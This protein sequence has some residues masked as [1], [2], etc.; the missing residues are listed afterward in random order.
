LL[1]ARVRDAGG[2]AL[3]DARYFHVGAEHH[4]PAGM[5][6]ASVLLSR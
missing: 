4:K 3:G 1:V 5:G 2:Q 6:A